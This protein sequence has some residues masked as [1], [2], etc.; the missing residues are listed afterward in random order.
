[1]KRLL[2]IL[3]VLT[4]MLVLT[5]IASAAEGDKQLCFVMPNATH[6]FM[7]AAIQFAQTGLEA[8]KADNPGVEPR[9]L[10]S[11]DPSEQN[12]QLDTLINEK[13][14][15][16]VL[17]PH[18]GDDLRAGAQK[19]IDAGIPLVVFD[20]LIADI[21]P[22]S[23]VDMDN[24]EYGASSARFLNEF[25]KDRLDTGEKIQVLEFKGD[26]STAST[27]RSDGFNEAKHEN[28]E[29]VQSFSTDWQRA[30]SMDYMQSF[31]ID[32]P[33]SLIESL[34]AIFTHDGE[35]TLGIFDAMQDYRGPA[36]L[37]NI[38]ALA[39]MGADMATVAVTKDL[40]EKFDIIHRVVYV[41]PSVT[42]YGVAVGYDVVNGKEVPTQVKIGY[43]EVTLDNFQHYLDNPDSLTDIEV[44]Y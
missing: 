35:I 4:M 12:N 33:Q 13:V 44:K 36:T 23:E 3:L 18:N 43:V 22:V 39:G 31:L 32:S 26:M 19:V 24:V 8:G 34:D 7:A 15:T 16:I 9:L 28:I 5:S 10:T 14:D 40:K 6:G 37:E 29:I 20:R 21:M 42:D 2:S 27:M 41:P 25:F 1:M 30:K 17:W 11:A 38:K